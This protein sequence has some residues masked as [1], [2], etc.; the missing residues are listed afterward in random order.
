MQRFWQLLALVLL[1]LMVPA[2]ACCVGPQPVE[3]KDTCCSLSPDHDAA[4]QPEFCPAETL[5]HSEL[6]PSLAM[7]AAQMVELV[8]LIQSWINLSELA[9]QEVAPESLQTTAPPELRTTWVFVSRAALPARAPS[10][11]G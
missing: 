9:A 2:S 10:V 5:A 4:P 7:P 6:P 3:H 1:A 11:L 8:A